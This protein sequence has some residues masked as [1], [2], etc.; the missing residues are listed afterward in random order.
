MNVAIALSALV[1]GTLALIGAISTL[2]QPKAQ[3]TGNAQPTAT[4]QVL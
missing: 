1:L 2:R 3:P 4:A